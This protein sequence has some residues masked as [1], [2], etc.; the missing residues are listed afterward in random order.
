MTSRKRWMPR[1]TI[2]RS[3][4]VWFAWLTAAALPAAAVAQATPPESHT[5]KTGDTL[6]DLA[7]QYLGDPFLWPQIYR[8][9]TDVVEDPH[10]IYP[11]EVLRLTGTDVAAVPATDTPLPPDTAGAPTAA[12]EPSEA[13]GEEPVTPE[14]MDQTLA[15]NETLETPLVEPDESSA[16]GGDDIDMTALFGRP[17]AAYGISG[18][19]APL[20]RPLRE[21]EFYSSGFLT[22]GQRLPFGKMIG[23]ESP[24]Q[25]S[26]VTPQST[27]QLYNQI[28]ISPPKGGSYQVGDTLMLVRLGAEVPKYGLVVIPTGQIRVVDVSHP[29]NVAEII[30]Q[31][32]EIRDGQL[33]LPAEHFVDP[34]EVRAV[35]ISDGVVGKVVF[36][37]EIRRLQNP[38]KVLFIDRGRKDGVAR[39]DVF[40]VVRPVQPDGS[41]TLSVPEP[42]GTL[43]IVRVWDRTATAVIV[44]ITEPKIFPGTAVRQ[45]AKLPT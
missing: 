16:S 10:W 9:N 23:F 31:F 11:G 4:A 44:S 15:E 39:G 34:G 8:L 45:I 2:F 43:Q 37:Q 40:E 13:T 25:I 5:V 38:Q 21:G 14:A 36:F 6:W 1:M 22:E 29:Q 17:V 27:G 35:P 20:Y 30:R 41:W 42:V 18:A 32:D 19:V 7:Q 33:V 12:V 3:G 28:L 26:T 24:P